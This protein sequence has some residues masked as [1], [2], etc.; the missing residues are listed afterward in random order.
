MAKK[1][2]RR[3]VALVPRLGPPQNLRPAGAHETLRRYDRTREKAALR[4]EAESGF[5]FSGAPFVSP[6]V[7]LVPR[8]LAACPL[9]A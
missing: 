8:C 9:G 1:R 5:P 3:R 6:P 7:P 2:R 4:R